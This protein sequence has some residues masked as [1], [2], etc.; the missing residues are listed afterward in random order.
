VIGLPRIYTGVHY[1]TDVI[2]G[3]ALGWGMASLAKIGSLR[4]FLAQPAI[5]LMARRP[6]PFHALLFLATLELTELFVTVRVVLH[7]VTKLIRP[8]LQ[9]LL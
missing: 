2:A 3:A 5:R 6:G 1:P 9:G 7:P 8:V 4:A